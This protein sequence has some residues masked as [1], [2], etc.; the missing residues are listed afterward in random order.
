MPAYCN[1]YIAAKPNSALM[2][3]CGWNSK[4]FG[5]DTDDGAGPAIDANRGAGGMP[6]AGQRRTPEGVAEDLDRRAAA[7]VLGRIEPASPR[8]GKR[9]TSGRKLAEATVAGTRSA[10]LAGARRSTLVEHVAIFPKGF[11]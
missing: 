2:V 1:P 10:P 4:P 5:Q 8:R 7:I 9:R 11:L 3:S 6:G